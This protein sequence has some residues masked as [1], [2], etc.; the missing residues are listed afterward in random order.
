MSK[1]WLVPVWSALIALLLG[2][3]SS[4]QE[5]T[6][7]TYDSL[8]RLIAS[9]ISGG[10]NNGTQTG[11]TFD[12]ADNRAAYTVSIAPTPPSFAIGNAPAVTEGGTLTFTVTRT[13][14]TTGTNAVN[15]AT[16][17]G[18][19]TSGSD[20]TAASGTLTFA[21]GE[22]T[23]TIAVTTI[24]DSVVESAETVLVNLS[25]PTGGATIITGQGTGTINDNDASFAIGN[26]TAVTEGGTLTYTVT[27]TG[28]ASSTNAVNYATA[29]G[30]AT[31]GSD[32]AA[33]SGTLTFAPGDTTKTITV[34]TIDDSVVESAET[35]LVNLSS[36]TGGATITTAQGTGTINDNDASFAIGNAAAVT[37]GGTLTF[38]VTRT[39]ATSSTNSV[40]YA[41]ASGTATSGSDFTAASGTLTFAPGD[42]AKTITIATIDDSVVE[43]AE[44]VLVNLS[45]PTGGATITTAQGSGTIN[46][47]DVSFA[48]GNATAVTEGGTLTFTVTRTGATS[49][50][51][52]VSYATASGTATSGSDFTAASGTLTFAPGDTTKTITVAT[53]DDSVVES[54]ETVLVNLSSPTGGATITTAQG[55]GTI[56]DNDVAPP[57]FAISNATAVTEGGT[58][59][60]T[61][62]KTGTTA[63]SVNYATASGTATSGS[64][65]TATS[66]TLTFLAGDT[67]KTI[68]VSTIDDSVVESAETVLVNLSSPTGGA[69]ITTA[70]GSGT[71]N[72]NDTANLPPVANAD[73]TSFNC[74]VY[75]TVNLV[76]NDTDPENNVPLVL[77]SVTGPG[78]VTVTSS[79]SVTIGE[80]STGTFTFS[81]VVRDSL[82]ATST[83]QLTATV[84][85]LASQCVQF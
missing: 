31:S 45:S 63:S 27:R 20:Y 2:V 65:F 19:A 52:S 34:A 13:G 69:T 30:T 84:T 1:R 67:T 83:G 85:G 62:T 46:D 53:I 49:S 39:G 40:S 48:I 32:F 76:A 61:V 54:A 16:A 75:Q 47:N 9:S 59:A 8:G 81:Y 6:T 28:G 64:D 25:S 43:S 77:V 3:P 55:T 51:N 18:T 57:S 58:L 72:D 5:T 26:A 17:D 82:G 10:P 42:T 38:T 66:G 74:S 73:T 71:I 41:T 56:N 12:P 78:S 44:T 80:S 11:T 50:T 37:E 14:S 22:T 4:A 60:F 23:K 7:Y 79:T 70:Q 68:T 21:A 24:D 35:V 36:P 29:S 33:A 15:F